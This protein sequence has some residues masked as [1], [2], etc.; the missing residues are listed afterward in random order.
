MEI[1]DNTGQPWPPEWA[2]WLNS[3]ADCDHGGTIGGEDHLMLV[4]P[5]DGRV[6]GGAR[7]L[8]R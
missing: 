2:A 7:V 4:Y 5:G 1:L 8:C 6:A 3:P